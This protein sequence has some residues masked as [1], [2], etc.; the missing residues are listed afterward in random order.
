[1]WSTNTLFPLM[2]YCRKADDGICC[3][4]KQNQQRVQIYSLNTYG[5]CWKPVSLEDGNG[6]GKIIV[7]LYNQQ[8][9]SERI[10]IS[11]IR[12]NLQPLIFTSSP[13]VFLLIPFGM[14]Q[15]F[16]N[17]ENTSSGSTYPFLHCRHGFLQRWKK[18]GAEVTESPYKKKA[19]PMTPISA[20]S[21]GIEIDLK[22]MFDY[23]VIPNPSNLLITFYY[24]PIHATQPIFKNNEKWVRERLAEKI[25]LLR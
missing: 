7:E 9:A 19:V 23:E 1:M 12:V 17:L 16:D 18:I 11:P 24:K 8:G 4:T 20:M 14:L 25:P 13:I 3:N 21:G 5:N 15:E 2:S 22:E 10:K 6:D